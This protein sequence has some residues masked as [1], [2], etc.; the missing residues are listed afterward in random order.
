MKNTISWRIAVV[1]PTADRHEPLAECLRSIARSSRAVDLVVVIDAS[2]VVRPLKSENFPFKLIHEVSPIR[3]SAQQRNLGLKHCTDCDAVLFI[4]DDAV[5]EP[6]CLGELIEGFS[7]SVVP[8]SGVAANLSNQPV[9]PPGKFTSLVLRLMGAPVVGGGKLV[10]PAVALRPDST[11]DERF[12][13]LDWAST[14]CVLYRKE[15]VLPGF[16]AFFEGYSLGED[17]ALSV[18]AKVHGKLLYARE[19]RIVHTPGRSAHPAH[20]E[21]GRMEVLNRWYLTRDVLQKRGLA[22]TVRF[23]LWMAWEIA[24]GYRSALKRPENWSRWTENFRGRRSAF[25]KIWG[26]T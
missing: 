14:T 18:D 15:A 22:D 13:D 8:V 6:D 20:V 11:V 26:L 21:Y 25:F 17:I 23:W 9:H 5:L 1:I 16:R 3:G 24:I 4:D 7:L 10:G 12:L 2:T 19:A